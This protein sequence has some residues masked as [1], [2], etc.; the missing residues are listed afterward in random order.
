MLQVTWHVPNSQEIQFALRIFKELVE[1]TLSSLES[2]L[3]PG[4]FL[5]SNLSYFCQ[6]CCR[7][8]ERRRLAK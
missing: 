5:L 1:P 2:L 8:R 6:R 4:M 3:E 7:Y